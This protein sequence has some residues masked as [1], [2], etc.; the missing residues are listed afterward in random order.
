MED[1]IWDQLRQLLRR[2]AVAQNPPKK[3]KNI[4]WPGDDKVDGTVGKAM[5]QPSRLCV[6][7]SLSVT[8]LDWVGVVIALHLR[9]ECLQVQD[10]VRLYHHQSVQLKRN[11]LRDHEFFLSSKLFCTARHQ[12]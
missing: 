4:A 12:N 9:H 10:A 3:S 2:E 1:D 6:A 7:L 8:R 5:L 11:V